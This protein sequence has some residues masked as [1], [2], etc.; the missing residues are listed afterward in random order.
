MKLW[1]WIKQSQTNII[2][3]TYQ[4]HC[5]SVSARWTL[6]LPT[7]TTTYRSAWSHNGHRLYW[8]LYSYKQ[9]VQTRRGTEIHQMPNRLKCWGISTKYWIGWLG[10][11]LKIQSFFLGFICVNFD[12]FNNLVNFSPRPIF[13]LLDSWLFCFQYYFLVFVPH[14]L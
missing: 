14:A 10:E 13:S 4:K 12:I 3:L 11:S 2:S 1:S 6:T 8:L 5:P 9:T 7:T